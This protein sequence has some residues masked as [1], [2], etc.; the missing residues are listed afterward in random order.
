MGVSGL[1]EILLTIASKKDISDF[2]GYKIAIDASL[3]IMKVNSI[4][5]ADS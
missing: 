1:W 2:S 5:E 4:F 3:W